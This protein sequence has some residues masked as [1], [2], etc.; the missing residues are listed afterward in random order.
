MRLSDRRALVFDQRLLQIQTNSIF[1]KEEKYKSKYDRSELMIPYF[2]FHF[3]LLEL[4]EDV[5]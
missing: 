5:K 2:S 3:R 4:G 1:T